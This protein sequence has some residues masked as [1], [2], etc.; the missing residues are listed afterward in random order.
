MATHHSVFV[1][2]TLDGTMDS[3]MEIQTQLKHFTEPSHTSMHICIIGSACIC[4]VALILFS[5]N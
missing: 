3:V 2:F 4:F 5:V 1:L